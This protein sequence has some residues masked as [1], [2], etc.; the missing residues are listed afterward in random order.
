MNAVEAAMECIGTPFAHQ[1]R[2]VGHGIDCVGLLVH[3]FQRLGVD[4]F[5]EKGYPRSP[6]D[7]KLRRTL[8][9][10][11]SLFKVSRH[12]MQAGD[13]ICMKVSKAPQHIA[14][15]A[16]NGEIIHASSEFGGTFRHALDAIGKSKITDVF[17]IRIP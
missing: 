2:S 6:F 10:Q 17:R 3:V 15:Y 5:D 12:D 8:I 16:G 7:G 13:V 4:Y 14:I 11:P 9:A 1:G